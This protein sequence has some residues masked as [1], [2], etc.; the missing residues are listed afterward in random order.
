MQRKAIHKTPGNKTKTR[1]QT[2]AEG[3]LERKAKFHAKEQKAF[4]KETEK[5]LSKYAKA[6]SQTKLPPGKESR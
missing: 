2:F 5:L 1:Q 3:S 6:S 4:D